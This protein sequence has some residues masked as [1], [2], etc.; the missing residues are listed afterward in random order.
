MS[1]TDQKDR[2]K[3]E[4]NL[5]LVGHHVSETLIMNNSKEDVGVHFSAIYATVKLFRTIITVPG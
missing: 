2:K 1:L 3:N 5:E 4:S